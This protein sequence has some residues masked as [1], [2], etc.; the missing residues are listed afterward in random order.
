MKLDKRNDLPADRNGF[1]LIELLVVIFI[2]GILATLIISNLQGAR[3]RAQDSSKKSELH[4][5]KTA[6]RLYYND[7]QKYPDDATA[8]LTLAGCGTAG[9]SPCPSCGSADF[10]AGGTDGCQ[11]TYMKDITPQGSYF[12]FKY[13]DCDDDDDFRLKTTLENLSDS[14]IAESQNRCPVCGTQT[15]GDGDYVL[16]AD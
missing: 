14:E 1:T 10:A 12:F 5:L 9:T 15:Y 8:N 16:C 13:Y 3:Q 4:Q 6:L 2:I 7:Y 11:T